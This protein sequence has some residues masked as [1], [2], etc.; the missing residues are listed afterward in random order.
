MKPLS[1]LDTITDRFNRMTHGG[2]DP[3][4]AR[5]ESALYRAVRAGNRS[6]VRDRLR[7]GADPNQAADGGTTPLHEAAYWGESDIVRLL[8]KAG[9]DVARVDDHGWTPL[10]AAAVS[11]G[12]RTRADIIALFKDAGARDDIADKQGWTARDYMALWDDNP[13]AAERLRVM[14][15]GRQNLK[16]G[17]KPPPR[18]PN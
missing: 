9:A 13:A 3:R 16:S 8:L 17:A 5:G 18:K 12:L 15:T 7:R 14:M 1:F 10:H 2:R 11:G 4:N 6:E